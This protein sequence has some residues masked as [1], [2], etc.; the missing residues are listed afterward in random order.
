MANG[1]RR[2]G[3]RILIRFNDNI[4]SG[5]ADTPAEAFTVEGEEYKYIPDG[6][7]LEREYNVAEVKYGLSVPVYWSYGDFNNTKRVQ[8]NSDSKLVVDT[9]GGEE[10]ETEEGDWQAGFSVSA[11]KDVE[12]SHIEWEQEVPADCSMTVYTAVV[13][14]GVT[15][16]S[17][18]WVEQPYS[19]GGS[20][21]NS[22]SAGEDL[23]GKD[24]HIRVDMV[25]NEYGETPVAEN[26]E[27]E[28]IDTSLVQLEMEVVAHSFENVDGDLMVS[29]DV[30]SGMLMGEG[31]SVQPFEETF[32]PAGL[33]PVPNPHSQHYI[34]A[35]IDSLT[36]DFIA[37]M[38]TVLGEGP[39]PTEDEAH[40]KD[41]F[42][43]GEADKTYIK[44]HID[45]LDLDFIHVDDII[46]D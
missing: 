5:I 13:D 27:W 21:I 16:V 18:D 39:F 35:E 15:P 1:V 26:M 40:Q 30:F 19:S 14:K 38:H 34:G 29:Y 31:G 33:F 43:W 28:I 46:I 37:I 11:V 12:S 9:E 4:I 36:V 41:K 6:P 8:D 45:G 7:L 20:S 42:E 22:V 10:G 23:S 24:F 2:Y 25:S 17:G 44:S 3:D 32:T